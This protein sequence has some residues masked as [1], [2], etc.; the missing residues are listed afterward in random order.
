MKTIQILLLSYF[1]AQQRTLTTEIVKI[2]CFLPRNKLNIYQ[3]DNKQ[4]RIQG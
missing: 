1:V 4:G 3:G 2:D